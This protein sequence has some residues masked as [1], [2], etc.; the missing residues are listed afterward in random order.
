MTIKT[1]KWLFTIITFI[2]VCVIF[3]FS[4]QTGEA[5]SEI[6]DSLVKKLITL[7]MPGAQITSERLE[8]LEHVLR[9]CAH[10]SEFLVLG[11]LSSIALRYWK[12][13]YKVLCNFGFCAIVAAAD[14]MLQLFV[15]GRTGRVMDVMIDSAGA[16]VGIV[17]VLAVRK[18]LTHKAKI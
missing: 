18:K 10:F 13:R 15:G 16:V 17:M 9:K 2:W 8:I 11:M 4:L 1:K 7:F 14:E 12:L 3:S 6:S 5:S